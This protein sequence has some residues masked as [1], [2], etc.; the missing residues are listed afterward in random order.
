[1]VKEGFRKRFLWPISI[2]CYAI[3][4]LHKLSKTCWRHDR[5]SFCCQYQNRNKINSTEGKNF[6][7][8]F[9]HMREKHPYWNRKY[10]LHWVTPFFSFLRECLSWKIGFAPLLLK[11][12][13]TPQKLEQE[14]EAQSHCNT[15]C[16]KHVQNIDRKLNNFFASF[17]DSRVGCWLVPCWS[18][19]L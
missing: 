16:Q 12:A 1:M 15:S 17:I 14:Q 6:L 10:T 5:S 2:S 7:F 9:F 4:S 11:H 19:T 3:N 8:I 13:A 18:S